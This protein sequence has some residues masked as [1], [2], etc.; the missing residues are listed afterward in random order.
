MNITDIKGT[1]ALHNGVEMPY[2][3]LGVYKS[4]DG[5]EVEQAIQWAVETGYRH[6]D[7]ASV[8]NNEKG[9]GNAVRKCGVPRS[10]LFVT[11]KVWNPDQG[12]QSTL[13]AFEASRK[14]LQ[15]DY[16]DLYLVHWPVASKYVD[17]WKALEQ[18][19][20]EGKVR[21]IGV[22]N[23]MQHHLEE[24]MAKTSV[25]PMVNQM[26]FHP[27]L[28]QPSLVEYCRARNIVYEAWRPIM[29]GEV[30]DIALLQELGGKYEKS[31]VQVTLRWNLQ[32][33]VATIPKSVSK[34]RIQE[35][36]D[37]FDFTLTAEEVRAIDDLDQE[38]RL[39]PDPDNFEF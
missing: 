35:N 37:L 27:Y 25:K 3:G 38:R 24:L 6:I 23:F 10:E 22:S 20:N 12:F 18:L 26:E 21:A 4:A 13:A 30:N 39:G 8:Y 15:L 7:T 19:Y 1:V 31:P 14:R 28:V 34:Q 5:K 29:R 32:K 36:G 17:T 2:L 11:T 33:G 16:I 9:V